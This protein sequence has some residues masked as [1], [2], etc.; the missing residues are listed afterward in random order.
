MPTSPAAALASSNIAADRPLEGALIVFDLDGTLV[1]TAPDLIGALNAVL[2][3]E[4]RPPLPLS[5]ARHLVGRGARALLVRGFEEAGEAL[6]DAR[7]PALVERFL[8]LYAARIA[9]ESRVFAGVDQ[10][11]DALQ[12][13]GARLAVCTNK[14]GDLSRLLLDKLGLLHR[15]VA[16]TGSQDAPA[17]KPDPRHLLAC[18]DQAG[19]A[20]RVLMVGDSVAD[21]AAARGASIPV[22]VVS[23]GYSDLAP[24]EMGGDALIDTFADL[25]QA[26]FRLLA[27]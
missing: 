21:V 24:E 20:G 17:R 12:A 10:A 27:A 7:A 5:A 14:P 9:D 2:G 3:E 16:I 1:E 18:V 6:S 22:V 4:G 25:P 11:L 13:A 23:F 8:E 26:A 19:G 15:F